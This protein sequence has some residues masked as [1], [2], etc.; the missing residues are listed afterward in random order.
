MKLKQLLSISFFG[1]LSHF[2]ISQTEIFSN[3]GTHSFTV[4]DGVLTL[5]VECVGAGGAGGRV[6]PSNFLDEDAAGGGGGGAYAMSIVP[7]V[8]GDSY[9]LYVGVGGVNDGSSTD[10][11]ASYW[12]DGALVL[13]AGG[14][15][16]SG[17]DNESGALGGLAIN[18]VGTITYSGG[19]G[20]DGDE[21][22]ADGGG[23]GGAAGSTGNGNNGGTVT[24]GSATAN[25]GGYGG[26]G[27]DDGASG[28]TGGTYGGGGGG[29]SANGSNDRDGGEGG[30]GVVVISY[31][32]V[33]GISPEFVCANSN[34]EVQIS[35]TNF[36]DVDS[37]TVNGTSVSYTVVS[38]TE[39]TINNLTGA[40]SGEVIVYTQN[41]SSKAL[42]VLEIQDYQVTVSVTSGALLTAN[43]TGGSS[44]TYQWVDCIN[45]N[46]NVSGAI[47]NE[48]L[49]T[50]NGLYAVIIE[51]NGCEVMSDCITAD[52]VQIYDQ[53]M[54]DLS[55]YPNPAQNVL[56][57]KGITNVNSVNIYTI[58]GQ[59][60]VINYQISNQGLEINVQSLSKGMYVI[61]LI[62]IHQEIKRFTFIKQ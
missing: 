5:K 45:M 44:A 2:S 3:T 38:D 20:G 31:C 53:D 29:S 11:E 7:V 42:N 41:G 14:T 47:Q 40:T 62:T 18:S 57:V 23:G 56:W 37:V 10:G 48:F 26:N 39:I 34:T 61:E 32:M 51:E 35:G 33:T 1:I 9:S 13:A 50:S 55:V 58:T 36:V 30:T 27:G 28:S 49:P 4:P 60:E 15:T 52:A 22:D 43:Y 24:A 19:N 54:S 59:T 21:G 17:N 8:F 46:Q 12:E 16:R 25:Y 6:T